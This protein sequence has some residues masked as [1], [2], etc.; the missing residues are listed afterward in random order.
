MFSGGL[1]SSILLFLLH[2]KNIDLN[3]G[4]EIIPFS[5]PRRTGTV[6]HTANVLEWQR[7]YFARNLPLPVFVGD[8]EVNHQHFVSEAAKQALNEHGVSMLFFG[9]TLNPPAEEIPPSEI[10]PPVRP[11]STKFVLQQPFLRFDKRLPVRLYFDHGVQEM[12]K[13]THSCCL[14]IFGRCDHCFFCNERAWAFRSQGLIDLG[15]N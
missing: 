7:N 12:L 5:V 10:L 9:D 6:H 15:S 4:C 2:K 13:P 3:L 14:E 11:K 1:D 8:P